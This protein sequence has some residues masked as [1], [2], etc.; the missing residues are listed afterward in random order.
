MIE[1]PHALIAACDADAETLRQL[2]EDNPFLMARAERCARLDDTIAALAAAPGSA[3]LR[4]RLAFLRAEREAV[5]AEMV[6]MVTGEAL[7]PKP[8]PVP[9]AE[10]RHNPWSWP[11]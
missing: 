5:L 1:P 4:R 3:G 2:Q 8:A 10:R 7:P 11:A 6:A 9:L